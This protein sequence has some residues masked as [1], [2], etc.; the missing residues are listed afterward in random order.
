[1]LALGYQKLHDTFPMQC[2]WEDCGMAGVPAS[3]V[4]LVS[5][6]ESEEFGLFISLDL[7]GG[8]VAKAQQNAVKGGN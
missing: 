4:L 8:R 6:S 1:M 5:T 3:T 2:A 7:H